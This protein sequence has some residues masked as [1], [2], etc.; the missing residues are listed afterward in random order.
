MEL[1]EIFKTCALMD[2]ASTV[3]L[4]ERDMA[5]KLGLNGSINPLRIKWM[6]EKWNEET[7]SKTVSILS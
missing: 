6:N 5:D 7:D 3:S 4:I 1:N 2:D